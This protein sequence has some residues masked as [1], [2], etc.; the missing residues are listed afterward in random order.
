MRR[1]VDKGLCLKNMCV[2][3][4]LSTMTWPK[5]LLSKMPANLSYIPDSFLF[6][7]YFFFQCLYLLSWSLVKIS[8][9]LLAIPVEK[10]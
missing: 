1:T 3:Q 4:H 5:Q 6:S 9:S 2:S 7:S 10:D 8:K